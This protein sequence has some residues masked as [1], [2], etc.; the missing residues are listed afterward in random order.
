METTMGLDMY[1]LTLAQRPSADVDFPIEQADEIHYWRKHPD[2]HGWMERLYR[3]KGGKQK[4]FNLAPVL[5][6]SDD[7][8][9]LEQDIRHQRLPFTSSFADVRARMADLDPAHLPGVKQGKAI[10]LQRRQGRGVERIQDGQVQNAP[11]RQPEAGRSPEPH[12]KPSGV[13]G[14]I[15]R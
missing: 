8:D 14:K 2:L 13:A 6:T 11:S 1:A 10:Q 9:R 3:A 12:G 5:L 4:D 15:P 7:L